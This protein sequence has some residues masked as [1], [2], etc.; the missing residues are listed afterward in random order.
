MIMKTKYQC[1]ERD[2]REIYLKPGWG[3]LKHIS[4][5]KFC[6]TLKAEKLFPPS[7]YPLSMVEMLESL[8]VGEV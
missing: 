6:F 8:P 4:D 7:M 1:S 3:C 2:L 5:T